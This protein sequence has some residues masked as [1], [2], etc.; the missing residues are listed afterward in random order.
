MSP[1]PNALSH[2][3]PLTLVLLLTLCAPIAAE[4]GWPHWRGPNFDGTSSAEGLATEW[5]PEKNV[6]WRLALPGAAASTP[7]VWKER[8]YLTSA[9]EGEK[10]LRVLAVDAAGQVV[11]HR[12]V[13]SG[14]F[15]FSGPMAQFALETNPA[16]PSPVTDGK[17][18]YTLF[19]SGHLLALDFEGKELWRRDLEKDYGPFQFYFGL[20]SSPFAVDG[21]LY[22]QILNTHS[23][24]VLALDATSGATLWK[25]ERT[26]DAR[27]ECLH[28][29][30]SPFVARVGGKPQ[31]V[32]HGADY[33]T[34]HALDGG[35]E[36]W[37][38][39][40]LN[41]EE[42]YNPTFRLVATP[43]YTEGLLVV[44]SAKRG[45][46]YGLRLEGASGQLTGAEKHTAW[47]LERGTPD[48]PSPVVVDG[49]VYLAGEDGR[50][51]VLDATTGETVYAERV[52]Q[53]THRASPV[54]AD[55]KIYLAATDGTVSVV[56]AGRSY[57]LLAKNELGERLAASPAIA[58]DTLYLRTY[59]ALYAI[60]PTDVQ[61]AP[62]KVAGR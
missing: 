53:S 42:G 11:W 33:T 48:V 45:P 43:V 9:V 57:E 60:A 58:G 1:E 4:E 28:S 3:W 17:R 37:R 27:Q 38:H 39:G 51:A 26:T 52:H 50:L 29:Y 55:G 56:R 5:G 54:A 20:S 15:D 30:A 10:A 46:V 35:S 12:D 49:L 14:S 62:T 31:L 25:H 36:L 7:I 13:S 21:R 34:G 61:E 6:H 47:A 23:Q 32:V 19:G 59:G 8:I 2:R 16:S 41:P 40:G 22:V 44:P 18:L 24:L